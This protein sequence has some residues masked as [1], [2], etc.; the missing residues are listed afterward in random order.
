[1]SY[2]R[3]I[4][5]HSIS[6]MLFD[7]GKKA[8]TLSGLAGADDNT[9]FA[10]NLQ[11]KILGDRKELWR[12]GIMRKGDPAKPFNID[13]SGIDKVLL[14]VE[15]C[16]DGMMYDRADWLNVKFTL[17]VTYSPFLYGPSPLPK[18]NTY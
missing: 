2:E 9:T 15:E 17:S 8:K 13:L 5:T 18:K 3:G 4:G 1:M 14:L 10:C 11:F 6:R 16:G 12:S 7:I